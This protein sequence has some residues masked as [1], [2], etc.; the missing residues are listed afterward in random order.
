[1]QVMADQVANVRVVF[2]NNDVLF[3]ESPG[4]SA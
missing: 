1:L 2:K 4:V 3:Q